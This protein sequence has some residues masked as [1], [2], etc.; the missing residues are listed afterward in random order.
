MAKVLVIGPSWLGDTIMTQSMIQVLQE[1][2]HE[3]TLSTCAAYLTVANRMPGL[4]TSIEINLPRGKLNWNKR[5]TY[6]MQLQ[7]DGFDQ[8]I[9][10]PN[11]W[12]SALTPYWAKIPKRTAWLGELRWGLINDAR[13]YDPARYPTMIQKLV[14]LAYPKNTDISFAQCPF[15]KLQ[16]NQAS[17]KKWLEKLGIDQK[18]PIAILCPGAAYGPAKRWPTSHFAKLANQLFNHNWQVWLMGGP[19]EQD[20]AGEIQASSNQTCID[21]TRIPHHLH[22]AIDLIN[23]ASV[24]VAN[25]SGLMHMAAAVNRPLIAMYGSTPKTF[26]PPLSNQAISMMLNLPCQ[27]CFKK[28]CPLQHHHCLTQISAEQVFEKII[29][30][31]KTGCKQ[32]C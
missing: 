3:V 21:W 1:Q 13:K 30:L 31:S 27:P 15:P 4:Q 22:D 23:E 11:S 5:K 16:A 17:A 6:G 24:V 2:G 12:K 18:K 9:V 14:A 19:A 10:V 20:L 7:Q 26:A 29:E 8:V 32:P 25:D 28:T